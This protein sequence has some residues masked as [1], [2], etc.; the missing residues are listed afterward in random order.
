[1]DTTAETTRPRTAATGPRLG[2]DWR[3][4]WTASVISTLGDGAFLAVLPLL[5]LTMTTDPRL[6]AGVTAWGTLPWLLA[7][8]PAG[9]VVDRCDAR[10]SMVLAQ[11]AQALLVTL[12]AA[13]TMLNAGHIA[14]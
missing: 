4:L 5:A 2:R 11:G 9:A 12:L 14:L 1:M 6:I 8:L 13:V 7:S 10:R 3:L